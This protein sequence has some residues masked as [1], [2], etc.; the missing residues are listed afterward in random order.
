MKN[1]RSKEMLNYKLPEINLLNKELQNKKISKNLEILNKNM[2]HKLEEVLLEYNVEGKIKNFESGPVITLFEFLP[3]PGIKA[4]K[5]VGLSEDESKA[6][7]TVTG[8]SLSF[9]PIT[10]SSSTS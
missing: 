6:C 1:D 2:S 7:L 4:S 8:S 10:L 3:A 9:F 5:I